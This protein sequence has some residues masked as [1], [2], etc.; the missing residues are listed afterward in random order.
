MLI[1][2]LIS[3]KGSGGG[4]KKEE[5]EYLTDEY[6]HR[7]NGHSSGSTFHGSDGHEYYQS[8]DNWYRR[9]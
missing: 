9:N 6:G 7:I 2:A 8:G 5:E 3:C 4:S 1:L